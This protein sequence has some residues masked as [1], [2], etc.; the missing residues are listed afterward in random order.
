M[1]IEDLAQTMYEAYAGAADRGHPKS[2]RMLAWTHL[3]GR[4]RA[5]EAAAGA[6]CSALRTRPVPQMGGITELPPIEMCERGAPSAEV[7]Q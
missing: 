1:T 2:P 3:T 6:A 7:L 5:W 4:R